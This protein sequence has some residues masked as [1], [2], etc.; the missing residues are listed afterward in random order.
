MSVRLRVL[1]ENGVSAF[2]DYLQSLRDGEQNPPPGELLTRP[3]SSEEIDVEI[4]L[5][6]V[7]PA[8]HYEMAQYLIETLAPI[9]EQCAHDNVGLW[10]WL[11]LNYFD[12]VCPAKSDGTRVPGRDYRHIPETGYLHAHRHLL[13]GPYHLVLQYDNLGRYLLTN[14]VNKEG[15]LYHEICARQNF[16]ANPAI[17]EAAHALYCNPKT[18]S[19][20]PRAAGSK[21]EP[22]GIYRFITIIQQLDLTYDLFSMKAGQILTLLPHEF[23]AWQPMPGL[24]AISASDSSSSP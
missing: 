21:V 1:R 7:K 19:P 12:L 15:Q 8:N 6:D 14:P 11:S 20:K 5:S 16:I 22:G 18:G 23:D 3:D 10:S 17:M 9:R 4:E 2:R 24:F 13:S